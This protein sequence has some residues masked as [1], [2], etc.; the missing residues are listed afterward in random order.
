MASDVRELFVESARFVCA[1]LALDEIGAA[2]DL[3]SALAEQTVGG[4][5]GHI[6]RGGV[7]VVGDYLNADVPDAPFSDSAADYFARSTSFLNADDHR[8]IRERGAQIAALGY[9]DVC[10]TLSRRLDDLAP[11]LLA[12]PADRV[13]GVAAGVAVMPLDRYLETRIVEQVVHLDDLAR[14]IDHIPWRVPPAALDLVI[15]IG[16]D[17]ATLRSGPTEVLRALYRSRLAPVLP[18][19]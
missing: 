10:A 16:V 14:S 9:P 15:R 19:L 13:I 17:I 5:A 2:W 7:W 18:V 11:R 1:V 12:E 8:A 6:A 3:P 4:L